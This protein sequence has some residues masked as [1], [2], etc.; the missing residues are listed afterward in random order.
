M[1]A[2]E[3]S[4]EYIRS[5]VRK[6]GT[7]ALHD[8]YKIYVQLFIKPDSSVVLPKE[9]VEFLAELEQIAYNAEIAAREK[10]AL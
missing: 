5:D 1:T 7:A 10:Y 8:Y 9:I 4:K 6:R 2:Q 3:I